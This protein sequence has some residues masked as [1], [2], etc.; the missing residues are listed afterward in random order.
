MHQEQEV[1]PTLSLP[2]FEDWSVQ[3]VEVSKVPQQETLS[4]VLD[5]LEEMVELELVGRLD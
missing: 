2:M 3:I 5:E 4:L 1:L